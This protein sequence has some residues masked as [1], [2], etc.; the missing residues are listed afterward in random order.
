MK[1]HGVKP[2][3][4]NPFFCLKTH[5]CPKCNNQ[6]EKT[7]LKTIVTSKSKEAKDYDFSSGGDGFL[8]GNIKFIKTAFYCNKCNHLYS[9]KELKE[10]K[11]P[12]KHKRK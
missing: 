1:V 10:A 4:S 8:C 9:I 2:E 12:L 6:L 7:K 5:N 11:Q 3:W